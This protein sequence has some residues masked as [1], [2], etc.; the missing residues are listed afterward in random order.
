M[1][2]KKL[3]DKSEWYCHRKQ[4]MNMYCIVYVYDSEITGKLTAMGWG[5]D[6]NRTPIED[7]GGEWWD[8]PV[9]KPETVEKLE[10]ALKEIIVLLTSEGIN[11]HIVKIAKTAL[12]GK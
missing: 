5:T 8:S 1:W 10:H 12:E 4:S 3:P 9:P 6:Y 11:D 7:L 2:T